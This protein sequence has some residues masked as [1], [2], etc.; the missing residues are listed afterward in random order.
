MSRH[1]VRPLKNKPA[2]IELSEDEPANRQ[3]RLRAAVWTGVVHLLHAG[4]AL[5]HAARINDF[6]SSHSGHTMSN[7]F[8]RCQSDCPTFVHRVAAALAA[9]ARRC[10]EVSRKALARPPSCPSAEAA[11][12]SAGCTL[13][14][15]PASRRAALRFARLPSAT[16]AGCLIFRRG[17]M[18]VSVA[19]ESDRRHADQVETPPADA[20]ARV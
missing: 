17:D 5:H 6:P 19:D 9:M 12:R 4:G 2:V 14:A 18:H 1:F 20:D 11:A 8:N 13:T 7:A 15:F 10:S 16:A 3:E